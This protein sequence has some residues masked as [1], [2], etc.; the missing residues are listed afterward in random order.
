MV[1]RD[2][3]SVTEDGGVRTIQRSQLASACRRRG[4]HLVAVRYARR[5]SALL[6][7]LVWFRHPSRCDSSFSPRSEPI[8]P[9]SR[10]MHMVVPSRARGPARVS[11]VPRSFR[12]GDA[13]SPPHSRPTVVV[14]D[15]ARVSVRALSRVLR[16]LQLIPTDGARL[17]TRLHVK[18][19]RRIRRT[20]HV[21]S[22]GV[23]PVLERSKKNR[24]A[25]LL[26]RTS[27]AS[28]DASPSSA[29]RRSPRT[30]CT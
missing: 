5:G 29:P 16:I 20:Q 30:A 15:H 18:P 28:S 13:L 27:G 24:T 14:P 3:T 2:P 6:F 23:C 25:S 7:G 10:S 8:R 12:S 1:D 11:T 22:D 17:R 19:T 21:S 26:G 9:R 4:S